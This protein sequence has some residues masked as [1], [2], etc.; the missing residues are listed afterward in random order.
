METIN[1]P[2][3]DT[4]TYTFASSCSVSSEVTQALRSQVRSGLH[5][6]RETHEV[7]GKRIRSGKR[8]GW[9]LYADR[10]FSHRSV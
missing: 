1:G 10:M 6:C 7:D 5:S 3:P 2:H 9:Q 4:D 8:K